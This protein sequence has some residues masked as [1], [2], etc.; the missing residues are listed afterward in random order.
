ML[1]TS[2]GIAGCFF[3]T[4]A[5]VW[6]TSERRESSN[7]ENKA[8]ETTSD[9]TRGSSVFCQGD[10]PRTRSCRFKNLCY[11]PQGDEFLFFHG[12][13]T[14]VDGLPDQRFDPAFLDLSSVSD[15]N[16][17]HFEYTD[18]PASSLNSDRFRVGSYERGRHIIF[19]RFNPGNLMHVFHDDL[20]PVY[21]TLRQHQL[22]CADVSQCRYRLVMVDSHVNDVYIDLYRFLAPSGFLLKQDL[23]RRNGLVCFEDAIV[24]L[25]KLSTWYQYGFH[26]PQGAIPDTRATG[27]LLRQFV[28]FFKEKLGLGSVASAVLQRG[29]FPKDNVKPRSI[30]LLSRSLNRLILNENEL[31]GSIQTHIEAPVHVVTVE[32]ASLR[33]QIAAIMNASMLIGMHGSSLSLSL[34]L[35][36]GT[37]LVELYPY[38]VPA[39]EYQ[40]YKALLGLPGMNVAYQSWANEKEENSITHPDYPPEY[41]GL[42]HLGEKER[43]EIMSRSRVLPHLCCEN[44]EWLYR[45]Y[46]DT[47][48]DV[49]SVVKVVKKAWQGAIHIQDTLKAQESVVRNSLGSRKIFPAKVKN[50]S[51]SA[52]TKGGGTIGLQL[53]WNASWNRAYIHGEVW[54]EIW[55]QQEGQGDYD[56]YM[57]QATEYVFT[58]KIQAASGYIVWVRSVIGNLEGPFSGS[59]QCY[60]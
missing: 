1:S 56:A 13:D 55:I 51:C 21:F 12:P 53:S 54:Y 2:T 20:L 31:S 52:V 16:T 47:F 4:I 29:P 32:M 17:Q 7:G 26:R 48:V 18:L 41:G 45:I 6:L 15:H 24:G 14:V 28:A 34:F 40:P 38:G 25:S 8:N 33:D 19:N 35:N 27:H 42:G 5:A 49:P 23:V 44:P 39:E 37:A 60:T 50:V 36:E 59:K 11:W 22:D 58:E 9:V 10:S 46:Q 3:V 57:L 30:V 43:E